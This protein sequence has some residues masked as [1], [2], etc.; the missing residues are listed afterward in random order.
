MANYSQREGY[1]GLAKQASKGTGVAPSKFCKWDGETDMSAKQAFTQYREGGDGVN[2]GV[3]L[4]ERHDPSGSFGGLL[5]PSFGGLLLALMAGADSVSGLGP[6]THTITPAAPASMPWASIERSVADQLQSRFVDCRIKSVTIEGEQ[7][8]PLRFTCEYVGISEDASVSAATDTYETDNPWL[9]FDLTFTKDASA[10]T[11]CRRFRI[12]FTNTWNED[13]FTNSITRRDIILTGR[14]VEFEFDLLFEDGTPYKATYLGGGTTAAESIDTGSLT[15][16]FDDG[17]AGA[18]N[19]RLTITL[20]EVS[21]PE[22]PV[23]ISNSDELAVYRFRG[24]A[25]KAAGSNL[26]DITVINGDSAAY[27]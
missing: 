18:D 6:Y 7:G 16:A 26:F 23:E 4:K 21:Y 17:Q 9:Y 11:M 12:T 2:P 15:F 10:S 27:V 22:S 19:R 1:I 25:N 3:T 13:F 20:D 5:R 24:H 14:N 8:M